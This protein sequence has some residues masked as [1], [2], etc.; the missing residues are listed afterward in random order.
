MSM[1]SIPCI[2]INDKTL[3]RLIYLNIYATNIFSIAFIRASFIKSK[4]I[5]NYLNQLFDINIDIISC[6]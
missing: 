6:H 3:K 1:K 4:F 5:C 2:V